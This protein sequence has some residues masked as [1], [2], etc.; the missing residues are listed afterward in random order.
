MA[1]K[2]WASKDKAANQQ[3]VVYMLSICHL[4]DML[5][6]G[7]KDRKGNPVMKAGL[8]MAYNQNMGGIDRVDQQLHGVHIL[9]K[10]SPSM[11]LTLS[12]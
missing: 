3:N 6:T 7:K 11:E 12:W 4:P 10:Q 1:S 5:N 9:R 2:H 8:V